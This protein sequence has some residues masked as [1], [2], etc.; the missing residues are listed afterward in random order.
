MKI[1]DLIIM[2]RDVKGSNDDGKTWHPVRC[3]TSENTFLWL[4]IKAAWRVLKGEA[5]AIDWG[6]WE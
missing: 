6:D 5:D 2:T 3:K 4:R 1:Q